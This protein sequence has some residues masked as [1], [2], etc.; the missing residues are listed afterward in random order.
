MLLSSASISAGPISSEVQA[1]HGHAG[2]SIGADVI[3]AKKEPDYY[4]VLMAMELQRQMERTQRQTS[5]L[6]KTAATDEIFRGWVGEL[7]KDQIDENEVLE[8]VLEI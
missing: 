8:L 7:V 2:G 3:G 5:L 1:T 6:Q 4:A